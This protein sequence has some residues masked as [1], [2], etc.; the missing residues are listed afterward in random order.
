MKSNCSVA[1]LRN[2]FIRYLDGD[3]LK[4]VGYLINFFGQD[5][6]IGSV[7]FRI[8]PRWDT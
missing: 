5:L 4:S 8:V 3:V 1:V 6:S 7:P 2:R